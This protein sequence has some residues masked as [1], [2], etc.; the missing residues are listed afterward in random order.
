[1]K[2]GALTCIKQIKRTLTSIYQVIVSLNYNL[3][4]C[5]IYRFRSCSIRHGGAIWH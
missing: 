5:A 4:P 1:M 3:L 2:Q